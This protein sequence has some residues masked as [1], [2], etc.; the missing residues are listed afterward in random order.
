MSSRSTSPRPSAATRSLRVGGAEAVG[1]GAVGAGAVGAGG[2]GRSGRGRSGRGRSGRSQVPTQVTDGARLGGGVGKLAAHEAHVIS[3]HHDHQ[4]GV[5]EV[6]SV[7]LAAPVP[8]KICPGQLGQACQC[9]AGTHAHRL[10]VNGVRPCGHHVERLAVTP[11]TQGV[12]HE[13]G[14]DRPRGIAG[15]EHQELGHVAPRSKAGASTSSACCACRDVL[16]R[17]MRSPRSVRWTTMEATIAIRRPAN[18]SRRVSAR[19]WSSE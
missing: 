17:N 3:L 4:I 5:H 14:H 7:H 12:E 9:S 8:T 1:A 6:D 10:A 11:V 18:V 15:A 13:A 2:R 16:V 19:S